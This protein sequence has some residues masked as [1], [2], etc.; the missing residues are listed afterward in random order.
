MK[1]RQNILDIINTPTNRNLIGTRLGVGEQ[2][3]ALQF[4]KNSPNG[5]MT[6]MDALQAISEVSGF[7]VE[8]ILE[9]EGVQA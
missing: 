6:K 8:D 4:R 1:I 9:N 3:V 7:P 2:S 5:R